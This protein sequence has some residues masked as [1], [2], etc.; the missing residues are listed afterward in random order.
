MPLKIPA[1]ETDFLD[2]RTGK[3]S[4]LWYQYLFN[5]DRQSDTVFN[6][7]NYGPT[8]RTFNR[9]I[10]TGGGDSEP[11]PRGFQGRQGADGRDGVT[12]NVY[13]YLPADENEPAFIRGPRGPAGAAGSGS[14]SLS[15]TAATLTLPYES[16]QYAEAT[17]VD[18]SILITSKVLIDWGDF[19]DADENTPDM[20]DVRFNAI[21]SAGS[22][23]VRVSTTEPFARLGGAYK[24]KYLIAT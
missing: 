15:F 20:D 7:I 19:T 2:P 9:F 8:S 14:G 10:D 6:T 5:L 16:A 11:G 13:V 17:V 4:S 24:I 23:V 18:A 21:V 3:V 12:K 1:P 22:M